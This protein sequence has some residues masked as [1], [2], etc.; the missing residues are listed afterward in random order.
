MADT[1]IVADPIEISLSIKYL[2]S[3]YP[4][5]GRD[6]SLDIEFDCTDDDSAGNAD[7]G[8]P[9]ISVSLTGEWLNKLFAGDSSDAIITIP[10]T[11]ADETDFAEGVLVTSDTAIVISLSVVPT[12]EDV[13]FEFKQNWVSWSNI[14]K[15]DF[16]I[17]HDNIAGE[18]PMD[19][20]GW[21]RGLLKLGQKIV[22]YGQ[23]GVSFL[24]PVENKYSLRTIHK[25][26][27]KGKHAY[28]GNDDVHF[29]IDAESR[30]YRVQEGLEKLD[31]SEYL[32]A[33]TSAVV[34]TL[35]KETN[36][37]YICDGTTGFVYSIEDNSLG[38]G[39]VNIT[40]M[41]SKDGTLYPVAPAAIVTPTFEICT[42]IYD[43][44]SRNDKTIQSVEFGI[45]ADTTNQIMY[46]AIEHRKNRQDAFASTDWKIV[47]ESG[48]LWQTAF[49]REFRF[50]FKLAL[51]EYVELDYIRVKGVLHEN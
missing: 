21:V 25:I 46:G 37:I 20:S 24:T 47:H 19:W 45:E 50:K 42:D 29:F 8:I 4:S 44:G 33:L 3:R 39:P 51:Y 38:S 11:F 36:L 9:E 10:I 1:N 27:T 32:S 28:A 43:F 49:G 16:T 2:L 5:H 22:S 17:G 15:L 30:L 13:V 48:V 40:G 26:G 7:G 34:M 35:D 18:R 41:G 12:S 23:N 31:Y 6:T 14:G